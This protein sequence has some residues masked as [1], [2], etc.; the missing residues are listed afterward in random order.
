[1]ATNDFSGEFRRKNELVSQYW[2]GVKAALDLPL[3]IEENLKDGFW[4]RSRFI[5]ETEQFQEDGT[6]REEFARDAPHVGC[7]RDRPM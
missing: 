2:R 5:P 3:P 1:M 7:R 4:P 6:L